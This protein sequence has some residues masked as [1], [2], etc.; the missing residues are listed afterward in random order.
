MKVRPILFSFL[1][2]SWLLSA[3]H[4]K[5]KC[6]D[7]AAD[8]SKGI[9]VVNEGPYGGTGT[10]SWHNPDTG[11]TQ[12]SLFE[13]ANNGARL[14]SVVQSLVFFDHKGYITVTG[15]NRVVV[16]DA[17][18]FKFLDTIGGLAK[19]RYFLPIEPGLAYVSQWGN[20][21]LTG[22]LA[23]INLATNK[24]EKIVYVGQGPEKLVYASSG[25]IFVANSGGFGLD[26][27]I[28]SVWP[29]SAALL[30]KFVAGGLNPA[31]MLFTDHGLLALCK[32]NYDPVNP[33]GAWF[34]DVGPNTFG[35]AVPDGADDLVAS[36]DGTEYYFAGGESVWV[37]K[38]STLQKLFDQST[39]GLTLDTEQNLLYCADAKGFTGPGEVVVYK[40]DGTKMNSFRTGVA[41]GEIV[42]V[43]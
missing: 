7:V 21:G 18:T 17:T 10:I 27:T 24:I 20:D 15:A 28:A 1:A 36:A 34:G 22:S 16:V 41:P 38:N 19:P 14:G 30:H 13:K 11:E 2:A 29:E 40:T 26:S 42:I 3:C 31:S 4:K 23:K 8:Y 37:Y 9:F 12:D 33:Q 39:Y 35:V 32:G 6:C 43:K 5:D 25:A